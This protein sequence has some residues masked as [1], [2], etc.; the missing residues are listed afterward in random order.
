MHIFMLSLFNKILFLFIHK[1]KLL[2]IAYLS[3][4][5]KLGA[6]MKIVG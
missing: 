6:D 2:H 4:G 1:N 5:T 3:S